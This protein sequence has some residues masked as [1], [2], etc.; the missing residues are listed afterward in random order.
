MSA[1]PLYGVALLALLGLAIALALH[2]EPVQTAVTG[3]A[4][5]TSAIETPP[6]SQDFAAEFM[7]ARA[8]ALKK[9]ARDAALAVAHDEEQRRWETMLLQQSRSVALGLRDSIK[10]LSQ[11]Q[12]AEQRALRYE[13]ETV[14]RT[15]ATTAEAQI[16]EKV[17]QTG[18]KALDLRVACRTT[19][20]RLEVLAPAS[21]RQTSMLI[22][23]A[24]LQV[25]ELEPSF[26]TQIDSPPGTR[27]TVSYLARK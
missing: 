8:E 17:S 12:I 23:V 13:S 6:P 19:V 26:P 16:L 24:L 22:A 2:R 20:C 15:W 21:E 5:P 11:V 1:K 4:E 18:V 3:T 25:A 14:D 27:A 9:E 7:A 10:P